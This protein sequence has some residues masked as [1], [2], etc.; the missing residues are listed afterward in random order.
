MA[1]DPGDE[2]RNQPWSQRELDLLHEM[3]RDYEN[4]RWFRKRAKWWA[5][6]FFGAPAFIVS[7]WEPLEKLWRLVRG[8]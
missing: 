5:L 3:V 6:W 1:E 7:F 2:F 4:A 8:H